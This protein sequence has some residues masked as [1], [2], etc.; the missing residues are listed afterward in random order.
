[1]QFIPYVGLGIKDIRSVV[2]NVAK[3]MCDRGM[4]VMGEYA[5]VCTCACM[6]FRERMR[7]GEEGERERGRGGG[8]R[9]RRERERE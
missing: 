6:C 3:E 5:I 2:N 1:M 7:V 9:E 8:E 4:S